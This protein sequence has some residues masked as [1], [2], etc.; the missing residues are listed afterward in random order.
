[1]IQRNEHAQFRF[2]TIEDLQS[3]IDNLGLNIPLETDTSYLR[4]TV[5]IAGHIVPNSMAVHPMEGCDGT[6]EGAPGPLTFR[7]YKRF[8]AGGA[9]LLWF[10][11]C[12][13]VAEGRANPRQI[14]L[15][16]KRRDD[17]FARLPDESL[18]AATR[19]D[20]AGSHG[21]S[22]SC[23]SPTPGA[24][25]DPWTLRSRSSR[26]AIRCWTR[27]RASRRIIRSSPTMNCERLDDAYVESAKLAI[28]GGFDAVDIKACHRY[29][30]NELLAS[31]TRE[32]RYGGS[33]ENRTRLL[34][35]VVGKVMA[36]APRGQDRRPV[37]WAFTTP[38]PTPTAGA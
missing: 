26:I 3:A 35:N 15:T 4:R 14:M 25:A 5:D 10:E 36:I 38:T 24:T 29:L 11:A 32:G 8:A 7:R 21:H 28:R 18:R 30:L 13:V 1:M 27:T 22:R 9:G 20:G 23:S 37:G 33:Y 2:A 19:V 17:E 16:T 12:A 34:R 31:H 6:P